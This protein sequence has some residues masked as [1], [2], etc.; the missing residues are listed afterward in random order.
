MPRKTLIQTRFGVG[1]PPAASLAE[2]ELAV[3]YTQASLYVGDDLGNVIP[4]VTPLTSLPGGGAD[5]STLRWTGIGWVSNDDLIVTDAGNVGVNFP[6]ADEGQLVVKGVS[7]LGAPTVGT[8][9]EIVAM[10]GAGGVGEGGAVV[11]AAFDNDAGFA[12]I[13]GSIADASSNTLGSLNFYTRN[14]AVNAAMDLVA[15]M[16][17]GGNFGVGTETP[18]ESISVLRL[19]GAASLGIESGDNIAYIT[20]DA[21]AGGCYNLY[22]IAGTE[23]ARTVATTGYLATYVGSTAAPETEKFRIAENGVLGTVNDNQASNKD[24]QLMTVTQAQYDALTPD[25][26]TIYFITA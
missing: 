17:A 5:G 4:L 22:N 2:A 19:T 6:A 23:V 10:G 13:K 21:A 11:F 3:D 1:T 14:A 7:N 20:M 25:A 16:T 15:T 26:N 24:S 8:L 18:A 9:N 12:A